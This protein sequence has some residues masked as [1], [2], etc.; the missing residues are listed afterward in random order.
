MQ[1]RRDGIENEG[2]R[3]GIQRGVAATIDRIGKDAVDD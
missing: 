2:A 3:V 1:M